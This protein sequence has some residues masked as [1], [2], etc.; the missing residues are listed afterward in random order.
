MN[1]DRW[2]HWVVL[3]SFGLGI[4]FI[5]VTAGASTP[6]ERAF[7]VEASRF[8]YSP[9]VLRVNPGDRVKIELTATDVVHGL[10]IDGYNLETT[11]DPGQTARIS[12][13]ADKSGTFR[14]HCTV[15]CGNMHPF[16]T[17]KLEVGRNTFLWRSIGLVSLALVAAV[18]KG[19]K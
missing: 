13:T 18:W 2:W 11:A 10:A 4:A 5:S 17:G 12:F 6:V 9:A 7:H 1:S 8:E 3:F 14:F 16:M 19:R 15:T